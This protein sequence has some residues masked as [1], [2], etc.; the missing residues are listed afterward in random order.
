[1]SDI[2]MIIGSTL[3]GAEYLGDHLTELFKQ[4]DQKITLI[5]PPKVEE[6]SKI[7]TLVFITSTHGAG[8]YPDNIAT[9][10]AELEQKAPSLTHLS[11][12]LIA[13]GDS[14]YDTFCLAGRKADDLFQQLK[15]NSLCPRLEIDAL[16]DQLPE[17]IAETWFKQ[18][19]SVF[20]NNQ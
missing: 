2:A 12:A 8:D 20:L 6:L 1:M 19:K 14:S 11:Y 7:H 16:D 3:G 18:Y 17:L 15:A 9:F 5:E 4:N 10:M 13:L